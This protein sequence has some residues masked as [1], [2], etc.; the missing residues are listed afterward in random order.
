MQRLRVLPAISLCAGIALAGASSVAT[1]QNTA[2]MPAGHADK[3]GSTG[4]KS[5]QAF[6]EGGKRMMK[7]MSAPHSGDADND[8][9]SH[10]IPHHQGTVV[11]RKSS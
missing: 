3:S 4:A 5:T 10:M 2:S 6:K 1:A 9:V 11:W 8:F 7:S